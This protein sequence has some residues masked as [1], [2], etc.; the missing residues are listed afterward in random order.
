M[1]VASVSSSDAG[2][3][4]QVTLSLEGCTRSGIAVT[5]LLEL[6]LRSIYTKVMRS[7]ENGSLC[8]MNFRLILFAAVLLCS[9]LSFGQRKMELN[10][11]F[12]GELEPDPVLASAAWMPDGENLLDIEAGNVVQI[13]A[14]TGKKTTLIHA[15]NLN[16]FVPES[17]SIPGQKA[18]LFGNSRKVW[19]LNTKGEY[20]VFDLKSKKLIRLGPS[21]ARTELMF[22]K[23]SPSGDKVGYVLRNNLYA[24][25][26]S[27]GRTRKLTSDGSVTLINGTFDWVYE[28]EL[29]LRDGWRWSPDGRSIAFWQL[30]THLEPIYTLVNQSKL[31]QEMRRLP[32]PHPGDPN[33]KARIGVVSASG[34]RTRWLKPEASPWNGY[35]ARMDWVPGSNK[36]ILQSL[37]RRQ[38][39]NEYYLVDTKS[40]QSKRIWSD[41]DSTW[42]DIID[43]GENGFGW[44]ASGREFLASSER[45]GYRHLYAVDLNGNSRDL[46]PATFDVDSVGIQVAHG[47]VY[48]YASP[49]DSTQRYLYRSSYSNLAPIRLTPEQYPGTNTYS[50][51]PKGNL[52]IHEISRLGEVPTR[53][54]IDLN[55]HQTIR[56]L[57]ANSELKRKLSDFDLGKIERKTLLAAD[58]KS[59]MDAIL[60]LPP[61]FNPSQRYPVFFDI[62]GGPSGAS[63]FDKWLGIQQ[64]YW[65]YLAQEGYICV[66]VDN[67]GTP[68]LKGRQWRKAIYKNMNPVIAADLASAGKQ[69]AELPFV[70]PKRIG[71]WGWST[72]GINTLQSMFSYPEIWSLGIAIAPL[73]DIM[74]YDSIYTERY[75][76][77]P[78]ES[79]RAYFNDSVAN[80]TKGLKGNLLIAYGTGD[81]NAHAQNSEWLIDYL[82]RDGKDFSTIVLPNRTHEMSEGEG[83]MEY[84]FRSMVKFLKSNMPPGPKKEVG[85][86]SL[87]RFAIPLISEL[88]N[89]V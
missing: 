4:Y 12:S 9:G 75:S 86:D 51:A 60:V 84:L 61:R 2:A 32:Y 55:S 49:K 23:I 48:F 69:V 37:N 85:G 33:A 5:A 3:G 88:R 44:S 17:V 35:L 36:L 73:A 54:V 52:A 22:A 68:T 39:R 62:Y 6:A 7:L 81:D 28:E 71:I 19:R 50:I 56:E 40:S 66:T 15:A 41:S 27:T 57:T 87:R 24:Y 8:G 79:K 58:G 78:S 11:V 20:A 76:G 34:G 38:N 70:D 13:H 72:G 14:R 63:A 18:L 10:Q 31:R 21:E 83:S 89:H 1:S 53:N 42:V 46:T 74:L 47:N 77:L 59:E 64:L 16:G 30:D 29:G 43:T 80:F 65:W 26:F 67:R 25:E 45:S 82:V